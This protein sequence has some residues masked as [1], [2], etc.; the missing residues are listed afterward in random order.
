MPPPVWA[1]EAPKVEPIQA[2]PADACQTWVPDADFEPDKVPWH[3][4]RLNMEQA[5][6]LATGKGIRIAVIDTGIAIAGSGHTPAS[7]F[8]AYNVLPAD[9]GYP[10]G[11]YDC[12]HGTKVATLI[13]AQQS[14]S[15]TSFQGIAPDAEI[16][17]I[18]ALYNLQG[19]SMDGSIAA[20]RAAIEMDVDVINISQAANVNRGEYAEAIQAALDAGIVVVAAAG[21]VSGMR[22]APIAYPAAYPGV[23][24]VGMTDRADVVHPD[25]FA[26]PGYISIAAPGAGTMA[27]GPS[28]EDFGQVYFP[29]DYGTSYAAPIVSGVVALMLEQ[30]RNEG[31]TLT[32]AE[33]QQRLEQSADPP[34]G[35]SPDPRLGYGIVNPVRALT[36]VVPPPVAD[37][38][39]PP[40]ASHTPP[41]VP[42]PA[43]P[44]PLRLAL[45]VAAASVGLAAVAVAIRV[46]L[47]AARKR[48]GRPASPRP[49]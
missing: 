36:G 40:S 27:L 32:P 23:I 42:P 43:D 14:G 25:S 3:L 4:T 17:G 41:P 48:G 16:I 47:P 10:V 7:R 21:N 13:G 6:Q 24:A 39:A 2:M 45:V 22:G 46:A 19:Q 38:P 31:I 26:M 11:Q 28:S 5:W 33:V 12:E 20:V 29:L 9:D 18:R 35:P 44:F 1:T 34:P 30:A 49:D 37:V 15:R 8:S